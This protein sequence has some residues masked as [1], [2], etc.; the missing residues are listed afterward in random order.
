MKA[1]RNLLIVLTLVCL[2]FAPAFAQGDST[3][4]VEVGAWDASTSDS[5]DIVSEY[6]S[7]DGG[8]DLAVTLNHLGESS[9][10]DLDLAARDGNDYHALLG[11]DVNRS[12]RSKTV[13]TGLIHRLH[14]DSLAFFNAATGHGRVARHTDMDPSDIYEIDYSVLDHRTEFQ[15]RGA[16][17]VTIGVGYRDQRRDGMRQ[18]TTVSHCDS[19]HIVGQSRPVDETTT[20]A[21][22]D[23]YFTFERG[24][25]G[26]SFTS[27]SYEN[28]PSGITLLFDDA[29]HPEL[30][31]PVFV[32]MVSG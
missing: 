32:E 22:L 30:R 7:N 26:V 9:A 14:H 5:P 29:G 11:F 4:E 13:V 15:P 27:R 16:P 20:D 1:A 17:N 28:D 2:P 23:A 25:V 3:G 19:C 24:H 18:V 8:L 6:R 31:A 12:V 10:V 21:S